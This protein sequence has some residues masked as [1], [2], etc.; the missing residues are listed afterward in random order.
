MLV[1]LNEMLIGIVEDVEAKI[2]KEV[3]Q[4][5]ENDKAENKQGIATFGDNKQGQKVRGA[6][7]ANAKNVS[8]EITFVVANGA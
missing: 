2:N 3:E 1:T 7:I 8:I 4:K 6:E 5:S